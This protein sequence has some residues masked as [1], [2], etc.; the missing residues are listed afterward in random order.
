MMKR[1]Q[2]LITNK[3][4]PIIALGI[5]VLLAAVLRLWSLGTVPPSPDWDEV[6]LGYNAYSIMHTGRDEYG[7]LMPIVLQ[8]FNDYKP[9]FYMYT[10]IPF[11]AIFGLTTFAV[12]LPSALVGIGAI[13]ITYFLVKELFTVRGATK[14]SKPHTTEILALIAAFLLAI[15]PWHIQFSRAAFEANMGL[16]INLL[17]MLLFLKGLKRPWLLSLAAACMAGNFYIYQSDRVF[18]PLL[19]IALVIIYWKE[20]FSLHKKYLV[21]AFLI[22]ILVLSPLFYYIATNV[23]ALSRA[24]GVSVFSQQTQVLASSQKKLEEDKA[25]HNFLGEVLHNRRIIYT[26]ESIGGYLAH[27]DLNWLFLTGDSE[28]HHAPH[29]GLLYLWELPFLLIGIY[30]LLFFP[31]PTKTKLL[32]FSWFLITPLPAAITFD[33]P[34]A[35]RTLNFLP[36]FQV[37]I[38]LGLMQAFVFIK[39][40]RLKILVYCLFFIVVFGNFAYYLN[41]YFVQQNYY[42]SRE[43]QYG[44]EDAVKY[45]KQIE[46]KYDTIMIARDTPLDQSYIFFLFYLKYPPQEYQQQTKNR[47]DGSVIFDDAHDFGKYKFRRFKWEKD[48]KPNVLYVGRPS[49]F[50]PVVG[51][52]RLKT[53]NYL[54]GK[55]AIMIVEGK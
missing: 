35:V 49:D 19:G 51:G 20:L 41:Q 2:K 27:F 43:W 8:S 47:S 6:A 14:N 29:M 37:F 45:V 24:K 48:K 12:R 50:P 11:I 1:L 7:K 38:A 4:F 44:Y 54:D 30:A 34:H 16:T 40:Y 13:L 17:A 28:R 42:S 5:I 52:E 33:V 32:I 46:G 23:N 15:S 26:R 18:T 10:T 55:P 36:T 9:A 22:G 39:S 21:S 3:K 25:N 31:F 53:I